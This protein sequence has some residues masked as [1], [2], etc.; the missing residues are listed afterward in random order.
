MDG[1]IGLMASHI[2]YLGVWAY[3]SFIHYDIHK[4]ISSIYTF[5]YRYM[6][7]SI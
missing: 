1:P 2:T 4:Y 3:L 6:D 5:M 7:M